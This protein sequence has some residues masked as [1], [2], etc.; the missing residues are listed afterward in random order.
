MALVESPTT[1]L[2]S[3]SILIHGTTN[4]TSC[5]LTNLLARACP[6]EISVEWGPPHR[7][8]RT[9]G[10][11]CRYSCLIPSSASSKHE[12]LLSGQ[13]RE[14]PYLFSPAR[15][16]LINLLDTVV[17]TVRRL[18]RMRLRQH[19]EIH[20]A[21]WTNRVVQTFFGPEFSHRKQV[22]I[23]NPTEFKDACHW[24]RADG[25]SFCFYKFV[26]HLTIF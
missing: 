3:S 22:N 20:F 14:W 8:R 4:R 18:L 12:I 2:L 16:F 26:S 21:C 17:T 11:S 5:T 1:P 6:T 7:Q 23:G 9:Y 24:K 15:C 19:L 13:N 25:N 10:P